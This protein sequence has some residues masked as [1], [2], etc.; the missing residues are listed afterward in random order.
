MA[1]NV[2]KTLFPAPQ[3]LGDLATAQPEALIE[4][5]IADDDAQAGMQDDGSMIVDLTDGKDD[6]EQDKFGENLAE[7]LGDMDLVKIVSD[8]EFQV[9]TDKR[10]RTDWETTYKEGIPLLG[11]KIEER[12]EPWDG[13]CGIVHPM[14][15]EAVVRFQAETTTETF[16]AK[17]PV[18]SK[19]VGQETPAKRQASQR[20]EADMN[21]LLTEIMADFRPEHERMLW[22]LP[23]TGCA[24][25]KVYFDEAM[26]RP[27]SMF[28]SAE[29][30]ILPYGVTNLFTSPRITHV[31]RKTKDE[32][33]RA[34]EAGF[35]KHYD[36][37]DNQHDYDDIKEAKDKEVGASSIN[38]ERFVVYESH[39]NLVIEGD[40]LRKKDSDCAHPYVVTW[41]K[42]S[43]TQIL[44]V[45]RNWREGDETYARREHF[46]QY[47]YV[48]GFGAYGYGLLHLIGGYAKGGTA[49]LRQIVDAGTLSNLP[50]GLKTRG[51]RIK[52]D[53][54]PI[55]PG[56]WRDV[57]V[58]SGTV[59]DNIMPLP[60]KEPSA[61]LAATL[62]K[63]IED[64]RRFAAT[65]DMQ[66]SDMS[67]QAPVGT[68]LAIL[69]RQLKVLTAV[70]ARVHYSLKQELK[71][72]KEVV[73]DNTPDAYDYDPIVGK[74][75]DKRNDYAIVDLIPVSDP[76][77]ATLSQ[78][79]V[80]YQAAIQMA[81]MAPEI[82]DLPQLHRDMLETLGFKNAAKIIPLDED[83][84]PTDPVTENMALLMSKPVK[85]FI[86]QDHAAHISVHRAAMQDPMIMQF[87][88]QN[89]KAQQMLAA[90]AAHVAEHTAYLYR[91]QIEA[92][93]G[94]TLPPTDEE[95]PPQIEATISGLM[96]QAA[97]QLLQQ[98]TAIAAQ[99]QAEAM[100][101][102]PMV[103]LQ[104][105]EL[106]VKKEDAQT[107]RLKVVADAAAKADEIEIEKMRMGV[108]LEVAQSEIVSDNLLAGVKMAGDMAKMQNDKEKAAHDRQ[109]KEQDQ[110]HRQQMD[111]ET[112]QL[113]M[114]QMRSDTD[115]KA[116]TAVSNER[117]QREKLQSG[118]R[119]AE[120]SRVSG[121]RQ[122]AAKLA[123]SERQSERAAKVAEK[124][125]SA[126]AKKPAA[127]K[128]AAKKATK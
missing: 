105:A 102:D 31:M 58:G 88:G 68:T 119:Q 22:E 103:Q 62:D 25:K 107:K 110:Q 76:N 45:R 18:K 24:F 111:R 46:V 23:A 3:G 101:K 115:H 48:P 54:T 43:R 65:A 35:Y 81:Q 126:A 12:T 80:Q 9:D 106:E 7:K 53:D 1:T 21:H 94:I 15:T 55:A 117:M 33:V 13:A 69:E 93:L 29:D 36:L 38:D 120:A 2:E 89:P 57:D 11:L 108:D 95:L 74:R 40:T 98:N 34:M 118:E 59:K 14:I 77:A 70:Q 5:E 99:Q 61:V 125:A 82:Y 128:P 79:V 63:I 90:A 32:L 109:L 86:Y 85:A 42:N 83:I 41:V 96:A 30:I 113:N 64:G 17:G 44:G 66:I 123:S 112:H 116:Y 122:N 4:I 19:I 47:N 10:S 72:L 104:M 75:T 71:L 91:Q 6:P 67:A 92:Q 28:I 39:A 8:L 20:V 37:G 78:R 60:Y 114:E 27:V 16:P 124:K 87:M 52:G 56:E 26:K 84:K 121:E 50:G 51:L 49:I 97:Q 73:R 127:K 100:A